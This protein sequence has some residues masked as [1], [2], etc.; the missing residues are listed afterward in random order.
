MKSVG[1][2]SVVLLREVEEL[3]SR[4]KRKYSADVVGVEPKQ[5]TQ[6]TQKKK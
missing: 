4:E 3:V 5:V 6:R 2:E 1:L